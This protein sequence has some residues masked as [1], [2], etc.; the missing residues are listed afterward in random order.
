VSSQNNVRWQGPSPPD[1]RLTLNVQPVL[2]SRPE[3][4]PSPMLAR[5][6]R[7]QGSFFRQQ[8]LRVQLAQFGCGVVGPA[9]RG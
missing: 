1:F 9:I 5:D 7:D 6:R 3:G 8:R 4:R 2:L